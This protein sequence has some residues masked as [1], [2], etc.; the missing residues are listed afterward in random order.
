M[1]R[2]YLERVSL[3]HQHVWTCCLTGHTG[4][5]YADALRSEQE[6]RCSLEDFP[7]WWKP[8][9]CI[10][11]HGS[12]EALDA[13]TSRIHGWCKSHLALDEPVSM[14][15]N[16]N[17]YKG[18]VSVAPFPIE[19]GEDRNNSSAKEFTG[20]RITVDDGGMLMTGACQSPQDVR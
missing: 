18:I 2:E 13:L 12:T 14:S 1:C 15:F 10:I 7:E 19:N 5:S 9:I 20:Y 16:M 17:I 8:Y 3:L 6:A 11:V 4:L